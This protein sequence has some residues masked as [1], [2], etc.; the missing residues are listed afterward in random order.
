MVVGKG[1]IEKN[2]RGGMSESIERRGVSR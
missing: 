1:R 2:G